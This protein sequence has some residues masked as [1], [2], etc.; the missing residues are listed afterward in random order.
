[1]TDVERLGLEIDEKEFMKL[2][3]KEQN[4]VLFK[5][6]VAILNQIKSYKFHQKVQYTTLTLVVAAVGVLIKIHLI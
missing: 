2:K 5:N 1:M 6:E 3:T 4:L